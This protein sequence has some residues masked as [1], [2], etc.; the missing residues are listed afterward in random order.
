MLVKARTL[1]NG[2]GSKSIFAAQ[3]SG[4]RSLPSI[5]ARPSGVIWPVSGMILESMTPDFKRNY[6]AASR[7]LIIQS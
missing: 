5:L 7:T 1:Q 6:A 4:R 3:R 2:T